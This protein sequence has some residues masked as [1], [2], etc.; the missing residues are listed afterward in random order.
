MKDTSIP[1]IIK[2][3][4]ELVLP[5]FYEEKNYWKVGLKLN[6]VKKWAQNRP[7]AD[8]EGFYFLNLLKNDPKI[9][10]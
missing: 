7:K 10:Q 3:V 2:V 9:G 1:L 6:F 5:S 8:K 4:A